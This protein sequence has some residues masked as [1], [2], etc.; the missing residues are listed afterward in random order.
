MKTPFLNALQAFEASY[1]L[2]SFSAAAQELNVTPAAVGQLVKSLEDYLG[3]PLFVRKTG[4]KARLQATDLASQA[5]TEIQQ[6]FESLSLGLKKLQNSQED[7]RLSVTVSSTFATKWLLTRLPDF[8]SQHPEIEFFLNLTSQNVNFFS[9]SVDIGI[10]YGKGNWSDLQ[11]ELW[12]QEQR[13]AVCSPE[14]LEQHPIHKPTDLFNL[15]LIHDLT[16]SRHEGFLGWQDWFAK[17][18]PLNSHHEIKGL[19]INDSA[20]VIQAAINGQGIALARSL[21]VAD[22]LKSGRLIQLF[23]ELTLSSNLAYY[24]VYRPQS[25]QK[26]KIC[27]LRNWLAQQTQ[28]MYNS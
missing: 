4:G 25:C 13:F 3:K 23:P 27:I 1:R 17:F 7:N 28:T 26:P 11:V 2:Q 24:L 12:Q 14:F 8:Q 22:D 6:G 10:R 16:L 5:I 15:P 21:L 19:S 9:E 20:N 18:L